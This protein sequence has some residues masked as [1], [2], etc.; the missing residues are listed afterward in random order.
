MS[1]WNKTVGR[2]D[3]VHEI[4]DSI[5]ALPLQNDKV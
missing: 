1:P 5:E 3:R 4:M 2:C